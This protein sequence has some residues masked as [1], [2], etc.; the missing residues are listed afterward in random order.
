MTPCI[1]TKS[2]KKYLPLWAAIIVLF[3]ACN[4]V[5][6]SN[7]MSADEWK[8]EAI[9][10]LGRVLYEQQEWVKVHAAEFLIWSG[11]PG[12]VKEVYEK[13]REQFEANSPYR[14]GIWRVLAQ[15]SGEVEKKQLQENIRNAFLD[16][17][18]KDR[19]HAVETMAK[20]KLSPLPEHPQVTEAALNSGI[21]S[22]E[23]YTRWAIAHT[24]ADSMKTAK[25]YFLQRL[26]DDNEDDLTRRIAAYVLRNSGELSAAAWGRLVEKLQSLPAA[27]SLRLTI[28]NTVLVTAPTS[29]KTSATY[30]SAREIF[31]T[32]RDAADKGARIEMAATLAAVGTTDDLELL[33][34]WMRNE[35]PTG[36]VSD[37]ADVQASAAYAI[38]K[39]TETK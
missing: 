37:D 35:K 13:E 7:Q 30:K 24:H 23:V 2:I 5:Q 34:Q 39:I 6:K 32:Y 3:S 10:T 15:V 18:G 36:K 14:I 27:N 26:S 38:L 20:L 25:E 22:L 11:H 17:S 19:I 31:D 8:Q 28:A 9:D 1:K 29:E 21:K 16:T 4:A 12:S 33:Q